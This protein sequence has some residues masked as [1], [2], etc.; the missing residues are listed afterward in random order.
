LVGADSVS[1]SDPDLMQKFEHLENF[2]KELCLDVMDTK[3]NVLVKSMA[4]CDLEMNMNF[5]HSLNSGVYKQNFPTN[6][7]SEWEKVLS[8]DNLRNL[9]LAFKEKSVD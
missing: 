8:S 1:I 4:Y 6:R 3:L 5:L 2:L 9:F 7:I